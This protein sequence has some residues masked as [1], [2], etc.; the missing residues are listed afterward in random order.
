MKK[1][2]I[3]KAIYDHY[4]QADLDEKI[5]AAFERAGREITDYADTESL[6]EFH[7]R[8]R[9]ATRELAGLADL[10]TGMKVLDLGCGIGG[11]A[12]MLAAEFGCM[13]TG[14]DLVR[15]YCRAA[16][17]ITKRAGLSHKVNFRQGDMT[18]LPFEDKYFDAAWTLHTLMNIE[19]KTALFD[20]V[21]RV[22]KPGGLFA[23][24]EICKGS[25][26][27]PV[28]PV[29][30]AGDARMSFL[31]RPDDLRRELGQNKFRELYWQ[32]VSSSAIKWFQAIAAS[33]KDS[34]AKARERQVKPNNVRPG[35]SLL[36]GKTAA[37]K[38]RNVFCN[39]TEDR[40]RIVYGVFQKKPQ[41]L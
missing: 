6:D 34:G 35:I 23:L 24:Y 2:T 10:K 18:A 29:P 19:D 20:N 16:E 8:G 14:I 40:I 5:K 12:R 21:F 39:L 17:M 30:W 36:L 32:D 25:N 9:S 26:S 1:K 28:F 7:I 38:S 31:L 37:E 13:V 27:P 15:E 33:A 41:I 4:R 22:L 11:P 3:E